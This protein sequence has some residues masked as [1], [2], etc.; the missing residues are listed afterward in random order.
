M[1]QIGVR[2]SSSLFVLNGVSNKILLEKPK[3]FSTH[4][5]GHAL[6]LAVGNMVC[7]F[8]K[9]QHGHNIRNFQSC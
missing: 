8:F 5:F 2:R 7:A 3:P 9:G 4:C 1:W 6:N